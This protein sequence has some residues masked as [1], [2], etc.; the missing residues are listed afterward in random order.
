M[1]HPSLP[2]HAS[3]TT[4]EH[5]EIHPNVLYV[6]TPVALLTT[7]N[8]DGT[9]NI[10]PMSSVWAL[11]DRV[12]LGM[13]STSMGCENLEREGQVVINFP[14]SDLWPQVEAIARATGRNPVPQHKEKIGYGFVAD[15]FAL[16]GLTPQA[17]TEVQPHRILECPLQFEAQVV[18]SYAPGSGWPAERPETF[19]IIET[20]V[21]R[22]HAHPDIV[23][24][25]TSHIDTAAWRPLF[26]VFRHYFDLGRDLGRTFKVET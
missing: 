9:T 22:V 16:S 3:L 7:N 17:S 13:S 24:P 10:S 14:S 19:R 26:Y 12:V 6:G 2:S 25:D 4:R 18:A 20:R 5:I 15:K 21:M 23:I 1:Q 8:P 11:M